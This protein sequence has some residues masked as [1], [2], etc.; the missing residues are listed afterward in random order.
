MKKLLFLTLALL[1][2]ISC[3]QAQKLVS[4]KADLNFGPYKLRTVPTVVIRLKNPDT[5]P[6]TITE[7]Y[8]QWMS[9]EEDKRMDR[10]GPQAVITI[11]PGKI[12]ELRIP[13]PAGDM[14]IGKHDLIY[15]ISSNATNLKDGGIKFKVDITKPDYDPELDGEGSGRRGQ[16]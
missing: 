16:G 14:G 7:Y 13:I 4:E 3:L 10:H 8:P 6:V 9:E 5:K 12:W 15:E 11:A 1:T 2:S